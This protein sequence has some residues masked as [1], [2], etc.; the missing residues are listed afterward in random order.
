M[1]DV[2]ERTNRRLLDGTSYPLQSRYT[3]Q[4]LTRVDADEQ[5]RA[6]YP[7]NTDAAFVSHQRPKPSD[8][9]LHY[10]YGAAAVKHW[11]KNHHVLD[12]RP[13]VPRP[14]ASKPKVMGPVRKVADRAKTIVKLVKARAKGNGGGGEGS[15]AAAAAADSEQP[16]W[17]EDDVMLFFWSNSVAARE[18]RA[19]EEEERNESINKWRADTTA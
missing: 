10:N 2:P 4:W 15:A 8:L 3:L 16:A 9:L 14:P 13:G 6:A 17:D 19:K 18:R 11:G 7:N 5:T 1:N 12:D